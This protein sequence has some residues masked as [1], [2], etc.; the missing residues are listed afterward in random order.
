MSS[1]SSAG[2]LARVNLLTRRGCPDNRA[3]TD[4]RK[5][6]GGL[7]RHPG[8]RPAPAGRNPSSDPAR[9]A[10][11]GRCTTRSIRTARASSPSVQA[12]RQRVPRR[13][14]AENSY[15]PTRERERARKRFRSAGGAQRFLAVFSRISPH[16]RPRRHRLTTNQYRQEMTA[17]FTTWHQVTGTTLPVAA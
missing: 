12:V 4:V 15:Q 3:R 5:D 2:S 8:A 17:R 11:L 14:V 9:P 10:W 1:I 16:F 7:G 13:Y 6:R